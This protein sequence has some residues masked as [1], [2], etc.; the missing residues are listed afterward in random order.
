M[1]ER[2]RDRVRVLTAVAEARVSL[3]AA[4]GQLRVSYRQ[5]KR[6][7]RRF[8]TGGAAAL[9]HG[10]VGRP[11]NRAWAPAARE[12][13]L[14]WVAA[15]LSG[16]AGPGPGQRFGP[17]LAAEQLAE[18]C[19]LRV[20]ATTL[21]R[22]MRMSGLWSRRRRREGPRERRARRAHFGELVQLDGSLHRW[23]EHRA[24]ACCLLELVDDATG[25]TLQRFAPRESTWAALELLAAW[26][27]AYGPPQALYVD[28]HAI[29]RTPQDRPDGTT[30]PGS[31]FARICR[32]LGIDIIAA[33]SP[34]AKG[35]VERAHGTHQDRLVKKMRRAA[36]SSIA[37]GNAFL[38]RYTPAHNTRFAIAPA[39]P[40]DWHRPAPTPAAR[41]QLWYLEAERKVGRDGVVRY[42]GQ[43]LQLERAVVRRIAN[44][45]RVIVREARDGRLTVVQRTRQGDRVCPWHP[46]P[47][48]GPTAPLPPKTPAAAPPRE[49]RPPR[50]HPWRAWANSEVREAREKNAKSEGTSLLA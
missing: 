37:A 20:P 49:W 25:R 1:S 35:R 13:A 26:I 44:G 45:S 5:A 18:E 29:Y 19:G 34:Q 40:I 11:S 22:W 39:D 8:R 42:Q 28:Y 14:A 31:Q 2:E 47:P 7:W 23:F 17:T 3:R 16:G 38:T 43:E 15:E 6:L 36:V 24:P 33:S 12:R 4:A 9:V 10:N 46:A 32:A 50:H 41:A 30:G 48:R 27:D 21:R